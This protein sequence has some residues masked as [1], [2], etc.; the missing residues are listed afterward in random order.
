MCW[1]RCGAMST[2]RRRCGDCSPTTLLVRDHTC[3]RPPLAVALPTSS[4][5]SIRKTRHIVPQ[6]KNYV[7]GLWE[8]MGNSVAVTDDAAVCLWAEICTDYAAAD[9]Q[10]LVLRYHKFPLFFFY[11]NE[12]LFSRA[13][14]SNHTVIADCPSQQSDEHRA[15][16][17][18]QGDVSRA[19]RF[20]LRRSRSEQWTPANVAIP[21]AK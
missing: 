2:S 21:R 8:T 18:R 17:C 10:Y 16:V 3:Y 6:N 19:M 9:I 14:P 20:C 11:K 5:E 4:P 15:T 13:Q 1:R 12:L 7:R